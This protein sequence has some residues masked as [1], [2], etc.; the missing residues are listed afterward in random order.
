ML[1]TSICHSP[2]ATIQR[3]MSNI[4]WRNIKG[5]H[6]CERKEK[7]QVVNA[8]SNTAA[9][10]AINSNME[11]KDKTGKEREHGGDG[12]DVVRG[13][14]AGESNALEYDQSVMGS[15]EPDPYRM[16]LGL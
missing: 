2:T 12:M 7:Q 15:V 8:D 13:A 4:S 9:K 5:I 16:G 11:S 1:F 10:V 14:A 3:F 6:I